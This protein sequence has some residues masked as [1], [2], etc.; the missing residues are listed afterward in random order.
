MALNPLTGVSIDEQST[1]SIFSASKRKIP[2]DAFGRPIE[3]AEK[4]LEDKLFDEET[5]AKSYDIDI[6][7]DTGSEKFKLWDLFE[8]ARYPITNM[9]Y[10]GVRQSKEGESLNIGSMLNSAV[11]GAL[12]KEKKDTKDIIEYL[13]PD[14]PG[15]IKTV[16]GFAGD[17]ITDP[18]TYLSFGAT[19]GK[20]IATEAAEN[21]GKVVAKTSKE[22]AEVA[23]KEGIQSTAFKSMSEG[24]MKKWG[25][26][27]WEE[28]LQ[29]MR[30][31]M[32]KE[33]S[34]YG[35]KLALPLAS[36]EKG[37]LLKSGGRLDALS[38]IV[39]AI[40]KNEDAAK[41]VKNLGV[42][43]GNIPAL[44]GF[45]QAF[46]A[47]EGLKPFDE[48]R[49]MQLDE[50]AN[51]SRE[52]EIS[53][54]YLK[55]LTASIDDVL[56]NKADELAPIIGKA[57]TVEDKR[58]AV[59]NAVRDI[60]EQR[61]AIIKGT[62]GSEQ[63]IA[64][65]LSKIEVPESLS[66]VDDMVEAQMENVWS[67]FM[68]R[69][70]VKA[71]KYTPSYF[72][73]FYVNDI[74][75]T[76]VMKSKSYKTQESFFKNRIFKTLEEAKRAG[77]VPADPMTSL[78]IYLEKSSN[79]VNNHDLIKDVVEKYG[80]FIKKGD[81]TKTLGTDFSMLTIPGFERAVVPKEIGKVL[82]EVSLIA[83]DSSEAAKVA[84]W[85]KNATT[86]W[87]KQA[88]IYNPGFHLRN[89]YSNLWSLGLKDGFTP[90]TG[91]SLVKATKIFR[92]KNS[93]DLMKIGDVEKPIKVWYDEMRRA[94]VHTGSFTVP[95][96]GEGESLARSLGKKVNKLDVIASAPGNYFENSSRMA[97]AIN[98]LKKGLS[99]SAAAQ[100]ADRY[101]I[102]YADVTKFEQKIKKVIPFYSWMRRNLAN[103]LTFAW[104]NPGRY[105][106][107]TIKPLRNLD[108]LSEED[109]ANLPEYMKEGMWINPLGLK[110]QSGK[111]IMINPNL[112]FQEM[113]KASSPLS[114]I[115]DAI[116]S[117]ISP[118][119]KTPTELVTN[120][121]IFNQKPIAYDEKSRSDVPV[122][123]LPII[124][125]MPQSVRESLNIDKNEYGRW[126][127]PAKA[128]YAIKAYMP[129]L[130]IGEAEYNLITKN[131]PTYKEENAPF[132]VLSRTAGVKMQ[133]IDPEYNAEQTM[134]KKI[135]D[136]KVATSDFETKAFNEYLRGIDK[137]I[138]RTYTESQMTK[139]KK[140]FILKLRENKK[141]QS[142][143]RG[144]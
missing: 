71:N 106:A 17:I 142:R 89:E 129:L 120:R 18:T 82:N 115:T 137:D 135:A 90:D 48:V 134:A 85:F 100:N 25:G 13:Y 132:G 123:L 40:S 28:S 79:I 42:S 47:K 78:Q 70:M 91:D 67:K 62:K 32:V 1:P 96:F 125:I 45:K 52:T 16:V 93:S 57:K 58:R 116:S 105:T 51:A 131:I 86:F 97:S 43:V 4:S 139:M 126:Q 143:M 34:G 76:A 108:Q 80:T 15:W 73:R 112:P 104:E 35:L 61:A 56:K 103:Q 75:Q 63:E 81:R 118:L 110:S 23:A 6:P 136:L 99:M 24:L 141:Q 10:E 11:Q 127:A 102:N 138:L 20:K 72:P 83:S 21:A 140:A 130:Q 54:E 64:E 119:I 38:G 7:T 92:N 109:K 60:R 39:K 37:I 95:E 128:M 59:I 122:S 98:D 12:L 65:A 114:Y 77:F 41:A 74:G 113:Q 53:S 88:T 9:I 29:I 46:S 111:P 69:D 124:N 2:R 101:F 14:A 19:A 44:K 55:S 50:I 117:G 26:K 36:N 5:K 66:Y 3:K 133:S 107:M 84:K 68:S 27:T 121:S 8:W 31:E 49:R 22:L 87:K 30:K 144:E 33:G 94:G